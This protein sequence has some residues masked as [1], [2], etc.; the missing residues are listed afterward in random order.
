MCLSHKGNFYFALRS[1]SVSLFKNNLPKIIFMSK[2][3]IW[4]VVI[5]CSPS[6]SKLTTFQQRKTPSGDNVEFCQ[7]FKEE[8]IVNVH[9][10]FQKTERKNPLLKFIL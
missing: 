5:V 8:I 6:N 4:G 9:K 1:F 7:T 2:R 3:H 10:L